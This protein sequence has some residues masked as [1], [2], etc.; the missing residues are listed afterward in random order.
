MLSAE[1]GASGFR[2]A[3]PVPRPVTR[4]DSLVRGTGVGLYALESLRKMG[5][6]A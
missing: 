3:Q 1:F 5:C 4:K 6:S 2:D